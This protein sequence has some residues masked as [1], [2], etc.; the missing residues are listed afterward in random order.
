MRKRHSALALSEYDTSIIEI[1]LPEDTKTRMSTKTRMR[2]HDDEF[3]FEV[4]G[5]RAGQTGIKLELMHG[6]HPDFTGGVAD[7]GNCESIKS[8][9]LNA[10]DLIA[11]QRLRFAHSICRM[12]R[13]QQDY[14]TRG[15]NERTSESFDRR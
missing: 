3:A 10:Q 7:S 14:V 4:I 2:H 11:V 5:L 12:Q 9:N 6:D 13:S 1:H 8:N 15:K